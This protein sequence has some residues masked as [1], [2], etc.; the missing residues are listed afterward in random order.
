MQVWCPRNPLA[1]NRC[2]ISDCCV[3]GQAEVNT[4][5]ESGWKEQISVSETVLFRDGVH[6]NI[7]LND[8]AVDGLAV[9]VNHHLIVHDGVSLI[10]D[11]GGPQS[12]QRVFANS[13][14]VSA[15]AEVRYI[16][17]S[18][19]DPDILSGVNSWLAT[20]EAEAYISLLWLRFAPHAD[21]AEEF[22][23]R[24]RPIPDEGMWLDLNGSELAIL[25]AHFLHSPGNFHILDPRSKILYSGDLGG[26]LGCDYRQVENF[27]DHIPF[28]QGFHQRYMASNAA[29][30]AWVRM[31][32]KLDVEIIAPQHGALFM[33]KE[34]I[35]RL[36]DWLETLPC[37]V[38]HLPSEYALPPHR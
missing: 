34:L 2:G 16:F 17:L 21:I 28:M 27:D 37:G 30:A 5:P 3:A 35:G 14:L 23:H 8:L 32:R 29:L 6:S 26:S 7:L 9:Q 20:T 18:H 13:R 31:V 36:L 4:S 10:L 25:P 24:L 11:P 33:G 1:F 19:Q 12:F 38:D 15:G 22:Q